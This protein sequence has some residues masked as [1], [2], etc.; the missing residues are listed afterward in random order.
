[1]SAPTLFIQKRSFHVSV[2][3]LNKNRL[4]RYEC[5]ER[6]TL[7]YKRKLLYQEPQLLFTKVTLREVSCQHSLYDSQH[8]LYEKKQAS[9]LQESSRL[10][11]LTII[12]PRQES[13]SSNFRSASYT[14]YNSS[15]R[16]SRDIKSTSKLS[17]LGTYM[18]SN[19]FARLRDVQRPKQGVVFFF[20][21]CH[22][23]STTSTA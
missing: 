2:H 5:C 18:L 11:I 15:L 1:M 21:D 19:L 22:Y 7:L 9:R 14:R 4:S 3:F 8:P 16:F 6:S 23:P 17:L 10:L 20:S 12:S 13:S